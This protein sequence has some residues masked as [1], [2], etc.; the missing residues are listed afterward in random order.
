MTEPM[1]DNDK[2]ELASLKEFSSRIGADPLLIQGAG[3]NTSVKFGDTM[4]IKASGTQLKDALARDLF[5]CV[6]W[7]DIA[8]SVHDDLKRADRPQEFQIAGELKPSIETCLHA[9]L[10]HSVVIHVHCVDTIALAMRQ[11]APSL[12]ETKLAGFNW[13]FVPYLKPGGPLA[14]GVASVAKP[15][16]DVFVLGNHGLIVA[17]NSTQEAEALLNRVVDC[18]RTYPTPLE[19]P[20]DTSSLNALH[21]KYVTPNA[22]HPLSRLAQSKPLL[23]L[24]LSG[25]LYPDQVLF[26][27]PRLISMTSEEN[28]A[29]VIASKVG[30]ELDDPVMILVHGEGALLRRDAAGTELAMAT[31]VGDVMLRVPEDA[32]LTYIP[33]DECAALLN[34]DAEKYRR[35][36]NT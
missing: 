31:S 14:A 2:S 27:G 24:A 18:L 5:V 29:Q 21:E 1:T 6:H 3:G 8:A 11:N 34:W 22:D 19:S 12:F 17:A 20:Q 26:C 28:V 23:D 30:P 33:E 4:W 36:I 7:R 13:A 25:G 9:V 32:A 16:T 15:E 10:S 35:T